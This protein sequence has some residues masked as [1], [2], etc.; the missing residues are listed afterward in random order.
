[1]TGTSRKEFFSNTELLIIIDNTDKDYSTEPH[2][3]SKKNQ[4]EENLYKRRIN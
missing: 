4:L 3:G 2:L 1:M